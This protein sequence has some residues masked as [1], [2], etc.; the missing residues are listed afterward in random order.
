MWLLLL[1]GSVGL[2]WPGHAG[3]KTIPPIQNNMTLKK[4]LLVLHSYY[5]GF[6]R[7]G[8]D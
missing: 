5:K 7:E 8:S 6:E 1:A 4:K 3:S 2:V